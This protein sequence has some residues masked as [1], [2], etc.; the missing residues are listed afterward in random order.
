MEREGWLVFNQTFHCSSTIMHIPH[1][2]V[3]FTTRIAK[4]AGLCRKKNIKFDGKAHHIQFSPCNK[5]LFF[6]LLLLILQ[7]DTLMGCY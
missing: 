6:P 3:F 4:S 5:N 2:I 7:K 1:F